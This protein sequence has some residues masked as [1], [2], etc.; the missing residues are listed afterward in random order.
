MSDSTHIPGDGSRTR[1]FIRHYV[2]MVA[3]MFLGMFALGMPADWILRAFGASSGGHHPTRMLLTM[4]VTMTLPM[5][6]WMRFRGHAWQP[7][8][9]MAAS[10]LVPTAGVL[11][12]LW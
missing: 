9:E 5:V 3:A 4:A 6:A 11:V 7:T 10:M 1:R 2:E 12:L 8:A